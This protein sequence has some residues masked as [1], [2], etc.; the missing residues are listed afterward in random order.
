MSSST[1]SITTKGT[2]VGSKE[3]PKVHVHL[4]PKLASWFNQ[5]E[6]GFVVHTLSGASFAWVQE[7]LGQLDASS[8]ADDETSSPFAWAKKSVLLAAFKNPK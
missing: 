7:L 8:A 3:H 2:V 1:V 4:A 5:I 6:M